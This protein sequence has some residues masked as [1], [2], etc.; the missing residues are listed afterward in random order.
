MKTNK[1]AYESTNIPRFDVVLK[2]DHLA[3]IQHFIISFQ[4]IKDSFSK[5]KDLPIDP[6]ENLH[7][8][9]LQILQLNNM[10]PNLTLNEIINLLKE[11]S[12]EK[13]LAN[14]VKSKIFTKVLFFLF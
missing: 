12:L 9:S 2:R 6:L 1:V 10:P 11:K 8:L 3:N 14:T 13:K 7:K 5:L 4:N